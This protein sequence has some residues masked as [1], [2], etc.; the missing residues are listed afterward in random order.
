M[1][2]GH[3]DQHQGEAHL[4]VTGK[5]DGEPVTVADARKD[6]IGRGAD[7]VPLPPRQ[8]PRETAHHRG[9]TST[10]L[11]CM[12][13]I[14]GIRVATKGM[15]SRNEETMAETQRISRMVKVMW[16]S[17][18]SMRPL[19]RIWDHARLLE[20][21]HHDE[22]AGEEENGWSIPRRPRSPPRRPLSRGCSTPPRVDG[23]D[24]PQ[25]A[26]AE[27]ARAHHLGLLVHA[28]GGQLL[29]NSAM[30][31]GLSEEVQ[32]VPVQTRIWERIKLISRPPSFCRADGVLGHHAAVDQMLAD[33]GG[34]LVGVIF[35]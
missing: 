2:N 24:G 19:A 16:P 23:D 7:E 25:G 21:A 9:V 32:P 29:F 30:I 3:G 26:Q 33:D 35:T 17:V 22:Q 28:L 6:H 14:R 10:P 13:R 11:L 31:L 5:G 18:R 8:A 27:A 1:L 34:H 12:V 20:A 15:L 4:K